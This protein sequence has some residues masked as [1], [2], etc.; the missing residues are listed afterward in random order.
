MSM[1]AVET[2]TVGNL[3]VK[4]FPDEDPSNPRTEWDNLDHM[5][6]WHRRYNLGDKHQFSD[7][8]GFRDFL[9]SEKGAVV[10]PLY[11]YDHS[12]I[13]MSCAPFSCPWDSGQVGYIYLTRAEI[14]K[15]YSR[16]R[17]SKK[18]IA[19]VIKYLEGEV[20]TYDQYLTGDVYGYVVEDEDGENVDSCCGFCGFDYAKTEAKS[21]AEYQVKH[22]AQ[23]NQKVEAMMHV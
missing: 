5:I 22:I 1:Q 13:T 21:A 10:L 8:Q 12:G 17:M 19:K 18:L 3:A 7:P 6:C 16:K 11:L 2:F 15:G 4:I 20:E 14:L 9:K 23:E